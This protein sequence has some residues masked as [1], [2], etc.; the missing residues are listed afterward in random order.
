MNLSLFRLICTKE[1]GYERDSLQNP[2]T[3]IMGHFS[4]LY[5]SVKVN[6]SRERGRNGVCIV[7]IIKNI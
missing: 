5:H 6:K 2:L 1:Q 7:V 4:Q 3:R